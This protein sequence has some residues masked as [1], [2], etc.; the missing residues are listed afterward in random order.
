MYARRKTRTP[1][2]VAVAAAVMPNMRRSRRR[3]LT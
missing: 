2:V 3:R 1:S